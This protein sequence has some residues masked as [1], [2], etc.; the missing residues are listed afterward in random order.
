MIINLRSDRRLP[1]MDMAAA[2]I[3]MFNPHMW[4]RTVTPHDPLEG[5]DIQ[6]EAEL[7]RQKKSHLSYS[8]R[9]EVLRRAEKEN[10]E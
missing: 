7:V 9:Q 5:V 1:R 3:G 2:F 10:N 8:Q 4:R 6:A